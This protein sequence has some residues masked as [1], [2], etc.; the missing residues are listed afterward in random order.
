MSNL[1][2]FHL[3]F[4]KLFTELINLAEFKK[5]HSYPPV[6]LIK[7]SDTEYEIHMAL[8]GFK[9]KNIKITQTD[10]TLSIEGKP[11]AS[12]GKSLLHKGI[13][14]RNFTY[15]LAFKERIEVKSARF[16]DGIL[17]VSFKICIPEE[18]KPRVITIE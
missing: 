6:D 15:K 18:K 8:A 14:R 16:N 5:T 17:E 3:Q 10:N 9:E 11:E 4:D 13:S 12:S 1:T 2:P 7:S